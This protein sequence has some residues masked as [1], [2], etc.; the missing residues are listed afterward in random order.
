[1]GTGR[2]RARLAGP[3]AERRTFLA[4]LAPGGHVRSLCP[5]RRRRGPGL[6][7]SSP[8]GRP[9]PMDGSA[10]DPRPLGR[11]GE[12]PAPRALTAVRGHRPAGP[13]GCG[14]P[15]AGPLYLFLPLSARAGGRPGAGR[16][17][18]RPGTRNE[19]FLCLLR[20]GSPRRP[21]PAA[22]RCLARPAAPSV[23]AAVPAPPASVRFP[24]TY[25][26]A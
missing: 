26:G 23:S 5:W 19:M 24:C 6:V 17:L 8:C 7:P 22:L 18:H 11:T 15:L 13:V 14:R 21:S 10:A 1:M 3:D 16:I 25:W 4:Q 2:G 12:S 20:G 9:R